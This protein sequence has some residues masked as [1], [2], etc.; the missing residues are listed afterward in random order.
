MSPVR[1]PSRV[2]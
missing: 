1:G 2:T